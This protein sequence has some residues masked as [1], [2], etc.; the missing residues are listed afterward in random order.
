MARNNLPPTVINQAMALRNRHRA[1]RVVILLAGV[2]V[3]GL[4]DLYATITHATSVGMIEVNPIGAYLLNAES[5][6][7]L[8]L[9][10]LGTMGVGVGLLLQVR[11]KLQGELSCW[12]ILAVMVA[13]TLHWANYTEAVAKYYQTVR[14]LGSAAPLG[15]ELVT[16]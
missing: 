10:K 6:P 11:H 4:G 14:H 5:I 8:I 3:L 9:F 12:F 7:G 2:F 1:R 15:I 16:S 13:L